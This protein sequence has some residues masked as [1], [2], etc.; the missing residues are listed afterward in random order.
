MCH[1]QCR[2]AHT[3]AGSGPSRVRRRLL[4]T[5]LGDSIPLAIHCIASVGICEQVHTSAL[6]GDQVVELSGQLE[7]QEREEKGEDGEGQIEAEGEKSE[8]K[9]RRTWMTMGMK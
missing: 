9:E 2:G 3:H 8:L 4:W 5:C 7:V 1:P 6:C